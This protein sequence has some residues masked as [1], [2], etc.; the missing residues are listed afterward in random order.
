MQSTRFRHTISSP[1]LISCGR[2]RGTLSKSILIQLPPIFFVCAGGFIRNGILTITF[3]GFV[4][5]GE[6]GNMLTAKHD[7]GRLFEGERA[8][9]VTRALPYI[10]Q[11]R[12]WFGGK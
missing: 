6:G 8:E 11:A 3:N 10:R 7:W 1:T 4:N 12:R 5:A 9:D 2:D